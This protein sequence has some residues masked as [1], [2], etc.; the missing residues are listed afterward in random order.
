[1]SAFLGCLAPKHT[2]GADTLTHASG[3][4]LVDGK[5]DNKLFGTAMIAFP[6]RPES[7]ASDRSPDMLK[8]SSAIRTPINPLS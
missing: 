3:F 1:M 5:A 4:V 7:L 6:E 8:R 2:A